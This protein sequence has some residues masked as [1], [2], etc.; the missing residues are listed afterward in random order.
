ME[1]LIKQSTAIVSTP[2]VNSMTLLP[3]D[4]TLS[5][6]LLDMEHLYVLDIYSGT[7]QYQDVK[8]RFDVKY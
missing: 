2:H 5:M 6:F 7:N 3:S 1:V 8:V 4:V